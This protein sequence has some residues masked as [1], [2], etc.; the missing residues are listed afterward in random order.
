MKIDFKKLKKLELEYKENI[1]CLNSIQ[2]LI[3]LVLSYNETGQYS[4]APINIKLAVDTLLDLGI[5]K[6][7]PKKIEK[8][9]PG[10]LNS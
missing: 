8:D 7:T 6:E 5:L 3:E 9:I 10:H 2:I 4:L 1:V